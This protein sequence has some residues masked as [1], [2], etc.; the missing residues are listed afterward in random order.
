[1]KNHVHVFCTKGTYV[2]WIS[3]NL[4]LETKKRLTWLLKKYHIFEQGA[5]TM[6]SHAQLKLGMKGKAVASIS[7][8][9]FLQISMN[10]PTDKM[11]WDQLRPVL[12]S[13]A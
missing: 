11:S 1:M 6:V 5:K 2:Q 3:K 13:F 10:L 4:S 12:N 8:V 7:T 9:F